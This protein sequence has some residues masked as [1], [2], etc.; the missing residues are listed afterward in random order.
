M[1]MGG[2]AARASRLHHYQSPLYH[3]IPRWERGLGNTFQIM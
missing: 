1:R 3:Q 2:Q